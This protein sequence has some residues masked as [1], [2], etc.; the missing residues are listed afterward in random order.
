LVLNKNCAYD[1]GI[2]CL[3]ENVVNIKQDSTLCAFVVESI[4]WTHWYQLYQFNSKTITLTMTYFCEYYSVFWN[5]SYHDA[6]VEKAL[7]DRYTYYEWIL[8]KVKNMRLCN[9]GILCT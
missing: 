8:T 5:R 7:E 9:D 4:K 6:I 2:I 3:C 1:N